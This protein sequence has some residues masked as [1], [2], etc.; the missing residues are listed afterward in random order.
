M[1]YAV[2]ILFPWLH[3]M[4][5]DDI[6]AGIVCF[7]LQLTL[8]GWLPAAIWAVY[9]LNSPQSASKKEKRVAA[10]ETQS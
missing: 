7:V 10:I 1:K 6:L 5:R 8:V 3:F 2:A 4:N 9:T